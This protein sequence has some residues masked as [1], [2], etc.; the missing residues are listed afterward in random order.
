MAKLSIL[1]PLC[2]ALALVGCGSESGGDGQGSVEGG[3]QQ[4]DSTG[5]GTGTPGPDVTTF[6]TA[7]ND[8]VVDYNE[9]LRTASLKLNRRLPTLAQIRAVET[10][11]DPKAEYELQLDAM[12]ADPA[13]NSRMVKWWRDTLRQGGG[14][15]DGA[16][17]RET[18]PV[19][20][21]RLTVEGRPF[22]ELFTAA[23]N[24]CPTYDGETGAFT[25]GDCQNG[26]PTH[27]GVLTN[28]GVMYQFYGNMA[29]R[30]VRWLQEVFVCT[31][32]PA[33]YS[34]TPIS[35]GGSDYIT[36]WEFETVATAPVDFQDTKSVICA[37]CHTT[38][39]H[40]APLFGAFDAMGQY[41]NGFAVF[42]PSV[43]DPLPT[44]LSHWLRD[45]ETT[46]WRFGQ[47]VADLVELG[48]AVAD[49]TDVHEC[50]V[51]RMWNFVMSKEDI[52]TDLSTVPTEVLQRYQDEFN[53]SDQNLKAT[54]RKMFVSDD[55]VRF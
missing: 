16:P 52:V 3:D 49:D 13:F 41:T 42:T 19:F 32:F 1:L 50:M 55:F 9:A 33:E 35:K 18:A 36:P 11:A 29:F 34:D 28:P 47:P 7:L 10:A 4:G 12:L 39:N 17:S 44:Q 38:I 26:V 6:E 27:A 15:A 43:P 14:A 23:T 5:S 21:A 22:R 8:R 46:A 45:G 30:R 51:A 40:I 48:A 53:A 25:D 2:T 54:L 24:T 20:A 37:N 31:K